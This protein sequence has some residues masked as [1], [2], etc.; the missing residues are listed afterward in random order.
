M[1]II[2]LSGVG[3]RYNTDWVLRNISLDISRGEFIGILGPNGSGKTTLLKILDGI[4]KAQEGEVQINGVPENVIKR[5]HLAKTIAVVAQDVE[6][7]FSFTVLEIVLMGRSPHLSK[8]QFEGETD[9]RI[10]R[11][12]MQL[13]DTLSLANRRMSSLSGGERQRVMIARAL[14]QEPQILLLDESTAFLDIRHQVDFFDLIKSLNERSDLTVVAVTHDIN[15]ASLYCDRLILM[16]SG[17]IHG[18]GTP[19]EVIEEKNIKDVYE[20]SVAVDQSPETGR[21]RITILGSRFLKK[22]TR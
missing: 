13:T 8:W 20:T 6:M 4:L 5:S 21:P 15:L 19:D 2:K 18:L 14:A 7:I 11:E 3:F 22:E 16:K 17:Q 9:F 12:A 1:S 10:A